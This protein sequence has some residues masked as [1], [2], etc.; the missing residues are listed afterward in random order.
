MLQFYLNK[1]AFECFNFV[2]Y[3]KLQISWYYLKVW[4]KIRNVFLV[5]FAINKFFDAFKP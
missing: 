5:V 3:A 1:I 4:S 2:L